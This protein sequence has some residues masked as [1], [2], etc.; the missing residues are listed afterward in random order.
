MRNDL[1]DDRRRRQRDGRFGAEA[2]YQTQESCHHSASAWT[3]TAPAP[4]TRSEPAVTRHGAA[5]P[6]RR[7]RS[8][9]CGSSLHG[10]MSADG[11]SPPK[12]TVPGGSGVA[13]VSLTGAFLPGN[14]VDNE[15]LTARVRSGHAARRGVAQQEGAQQEIAECGAKLCQHRAARSG[16][17]SGARNELD[18]KTHRPGA[19]SRKHGSRSQRAADA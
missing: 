1:P 18:E 3:P 19:L 14:P 10:E 9:L 4:P 13:P 16:S 11:A 6:L 5:R 8:V 15:Q 12:V 2:N 17:R 7:T